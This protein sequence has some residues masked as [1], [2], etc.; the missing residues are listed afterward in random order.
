[1]AKLNIRK[2]LSRFRK[3]EEGASTVE[4]VIVMGVFTA[5]FAWTIETG[6]IMFRWVNMEQAVETVSRD[7]RL[8]GLAEK[9][10]DPN[11]P[12]YVAGAGHDFIKNEICDAVVGISDCNNSI[13]VEITNLDIDA[14]TP[15][16]APRCRDKTEDWDAATAPV[17]DPGARGDETTTTVAYMRVCIVMDTLLAPNYSLPFKREPDGG[18]AIVVDTA[19]ISEPT[20]NTSG[21]LG[22]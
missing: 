12:E 22:S 13:M 19:F 11:H 14:G 15:T 8:F 4:S 21:G 20:N 9:Y 10:T 18:I 2:L 3:N 17:L 6:F 1:M 7:I 16:I 5:I